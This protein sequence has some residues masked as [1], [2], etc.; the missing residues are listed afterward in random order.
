[1]LRSGGGR[2]RDFDRHKALVSGDQKA[3]F[4]QGL[5]KDKRAAE[6]ESVAVKAYF[7]LFL[8]IGGDQDTGDIF[9]VVEGRKVARR[10][11][12]M[13]REFCAADAGDELKVKI[14]VRK[15]AALVAQYKIGLVGSKQSVKLLVIAVYYMYGY[16]GISR[17]KF[18]YRFAQFGAPVCAQVAD[19]EP[20]GVAPADAYRFEFQLF[21][22]AQEYTPV[23]VEVSPRLG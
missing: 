11:R 12:V 14:S 2:G 13:F 17:R 4:V 20:Q 15:S 7:A 1:M 21:G 6:A 23:S 18:R 22:V 5:G 8:F 10:E 9:Q 19:I 3:A 16:I